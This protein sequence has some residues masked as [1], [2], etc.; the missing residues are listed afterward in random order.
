MFNSII[1]KLSI[2]LSNP[3]P[4]ETAQ[5]RMAPEG[6]NNFKY[7]EK[8][9]LAAVLILLFPK[10]NELFT[11]F[12]KRP[13][14]PGVHS[15]QISFPGGKYE[16]SDA[17]LEHTALRESFEE[18]GIQINSVK[19]IGKLSPLHIPVSSF[20][21]HPFIGYIENK[22]VWRPDEKEVSRVIELPLSYL[23]N[24]NCIKHEVWDLHN[25]KL[26]VPF[27]YAD[28][29]K[30]WGATAMITSEFLEIYTSSLKA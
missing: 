3:L 2:E 26:N 16:L 15:G 22:P 23:S 8:T 24:P 11:V 6:R 21:V 20:I 17:N 14:Y 28:N 4:G 10:N 1:E 9:S 25:L 13:D 30:I 19:I 12:M 7:A 27:Y 29:E 5:F 18:L